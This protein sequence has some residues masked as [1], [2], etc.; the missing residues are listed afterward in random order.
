MMAVVAVVAD[1]SVAVVASTVILAAE[2][3]FDKML[4]SHADLGP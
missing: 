1:A 4:A 2:P 3:P